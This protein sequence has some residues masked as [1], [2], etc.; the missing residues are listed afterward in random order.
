MGGTE[1]SLLQDTGYPLQ[2]VE[3]AL[4]GREDASLRATLENAGTHDVPQAG[5]T[6]PYR[7][8][9][10]HEVILLACLQGCHA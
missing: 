10:L 7:P 1:P 5:S 8:K 3:G 4:H 2:A 9:E 6:G